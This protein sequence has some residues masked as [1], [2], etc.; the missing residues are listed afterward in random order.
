MTATCVALIGRCGLLRHTANRHLHSRRDHLAD[1]PRIVI[2]IRFGR[3]ARPAVQ[4]HFNPGVPVDHSADP[5]EAL[6][7]AAPRYTANA[8][9]QANLVFFW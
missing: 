6:R 5:A 3:T 2:Q 7:G 8:I 4:Q 1:G 9:V